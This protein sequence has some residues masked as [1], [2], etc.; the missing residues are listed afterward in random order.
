MLALDTNQKAAVCSSAERLVIVAGAGSGK[1]RVF[2]ARI[3]HIVDS[4]YAPGRI[5]AM[6]FTRAAARE[7]KQRLLQMRPSLRGVTIGTFHSVFF[8]LINEYAPRIGYRRPITPYDEYFATDILA[9]VMIA[10]GLPYSNRAQNES[11]RGK[12]PKMIRRAVDKLA[13]DNEY[14]W[15][16]VQEEYRKILRA[17]NAVSYDEMIHQA[18]ELLDKNPDVLQELRNL[19]QWVLVDEAQDTDDRQLGMIMKLRP[20]Y[21]TLVGDD[22]QAIYEWRG[23]N[24]RG[25]INLSRQPGVELIHLDTNYRS[26]KSIVQA[27]NLLL[28]H[29]QNQIP[30]EIDSTWYAP[31]GVCRYVWL[32]SDGDHILDAANLVATQIFQGGR[33][34]GELAVLCRTNRLA[35]E[36]SRRLKYMN[37]PHRLISRG[38]FWESSAVRNI[39][40]NLTL[41]INIYD[42]AAWNKAI[43]FPY[44][45]ISPL[46]RA[47]IRR[48]A[49]KGRVPLLCAGAWLAMEET[50]DPHLQE[51]VQWT[52]E[53][54]TV[55]GQ[56]RQSK[57]QGAEWSAD[58]CIDELNE[59]LGWLAYF[60][61]LPSTMTFPGVIIDRFKMQI[62]ALQTDD[63]PVEARELLEWYA[64]RDMQEEAE[65]DETLVT[66][67]TIH[68]AKGLEWPVVILPGW[69]P[70]IFPSKRSIKE[71]RLE[72]ERRLAY[73][74]VTRAQ[75][76]CYIFGGASPCR[77]VDE[78][79]LLSD[80]GDD[81]DNEF[82]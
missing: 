77:F 40:A 16:R 41:L 35:D 30:R 5:L 28:K 78:A 20:Q 57:K 24:P 53:F 12:D 55:V 52:I 51:I 74:A 29:N 75:D 65:T 14:D 39:I 19:W 56:Y 11:L 2:T 36:T 71:G 61:M 3:L 26:A 25:I 64:T 50:Y 9:D 66:V 43:N 6:T 34:P 68:A 45:R 48:Y 63:E 44:A 72:E 17:H 79:E 21:L 15:I 62:K 46:V 47:A 22:G 60:K 82:F 70:D 4:G 42:N 73:V 7:I 81:Y 76:E 23:A 18:N 8:R 69:T 37:V 67:C 13:R 58:R 31:D 59:K 49:I 32:G 1:T 80:E 54:L 33:K 27:S 10:M 38:S